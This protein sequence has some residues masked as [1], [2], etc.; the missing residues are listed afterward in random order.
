MTRSKKRSER[1][2][3]NKIVLRASGETYFDSLDVNKRGE[4]EL[5]AFLGVLQRAG[6]RAD[7]P[8]L[9]SLYTKPAHRLRELNSSLLRPLGVSI[10]TQACSLVVL[11]E[12]NLRSLT[13]TRLVRA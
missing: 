8:R 3:L 11:C 7:D 6:L 1:L 13:L 2:N 12:V 9:S 10:L 5:D 4:V